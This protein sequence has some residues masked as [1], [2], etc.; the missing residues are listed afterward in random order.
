VTRKLNWGQDR[1]TYY[2]R[3]GQLHSMP[4]S[5]TDLGR[6]DQWVGA[7]GRRTEFRLEDLLE[8][9]ALLR[10]LTNTLREV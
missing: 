3:R 4:T 7:A 6:L 10:T 2:D 5:W 9:A 8:L 1:V